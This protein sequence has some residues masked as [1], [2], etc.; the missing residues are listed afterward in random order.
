MPSPPYLKGVVTSR[1][2]V[3]GVLSSTRSLEVRPVEIVTGHTELEI[4][5]EDYSINGPIERLPDGDGCLEL[6]RTWKAVWMLECLN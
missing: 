1:R 4:L 2:G 5:S 6:Q 3:D